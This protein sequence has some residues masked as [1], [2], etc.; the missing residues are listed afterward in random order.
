MESKRGGGGCIRIYRIEPVQ[1]RPWQEV[2]AAMESEDFEPR[3]IRQL[4]SRMYDE[5][6]IS[7]REAHLLQTVLQDRIYRS[8][9][10]NLNQ[11]RI[12]QR[13]LLGAVL[14]EFLKG[15]YQ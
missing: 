11:A 5:K 6:I 8:C 10:I 15:S 3:R 7:R 1:N 12:L 14:E 4:I 9:N 2:L 13:S